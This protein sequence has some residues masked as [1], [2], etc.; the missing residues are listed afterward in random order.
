MNPLTENA[1]V[2]HSYTRDDA[3]EENYMIS[4][5]MLELAKGGRFRKVCHSWENVTCVTVT[6]N[7]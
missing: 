7:S 6:I 4:T 3:M 1:T 2:E 5:V